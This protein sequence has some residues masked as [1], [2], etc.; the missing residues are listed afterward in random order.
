MK[1]R[2]LG[3][4]EVVHGGRPLSIR[5]ARQRAVL[6]ALLVD[7]NRVVPL[8]VLVARVWD[9][10]PPSRTALHNLVMRLRHALGPDVIETRA[11]GYL[12]E[13]SDEDL[14]V[15][16]FDDLVRRA[17]TADPRQAS[18]LLTE[19]L[20]LWRGEPLADVP[21]EVLHREVVPGLVERRLAAVELRIEAD[22][23]LGGHSDLVPELREL[24]D[25]H[26]LREHFWH[27]RMRALHL[28]GRQAEALDCFRQVREVLR[29]ELGVDPGPELRALHQRILV[30]EHRRPT[31]TPVPRQ[32]PTR[33]P[34]FVGRA[35]ELRHLG[36]LLDVAA[37]TVVISAVNGSAGIGKTTLAV[38]WAHQ[39]AD[40][41][42]DGQLYVDLRGFDADNAPTPPS[43]AV[44]GFLTALDVPSER[45]PATLD[46]QTALYRSLLAD[47]RVLVLLDNARDADQVRPLL[48]ASPTCLVLITSRNQLTGLVA[49][50]GARPIPLD[51][52][53]EADALA[54]L[55]GHLGARRVDADPEAAAELVEHCA[56]VPLAVALMAARAAVNARLSLRDLA[57]DLR[58][59]HTRL[60]T[61]DD[62]DP[63]NGVRAVFSYSYRQVSP[64]AARLFRLLGSHPGPDVSVAAAASL[65]GVPITEANGLVDE[66]AAAHLLHAPTPGRFA[67]HDLL[68][69]YAVEQPDD[70][71]RDAVRRLL[72]HYRYAAAEANRLVHVARSPVDLDAP[73]PDVH[74]ESFAGIEAAA[75]WWDAEH[76][77]LV[78]AV[79]LAAKQGFDRHAWQIAWAIAVDLD[80][81]G[82]WV[83]W[84]DTQ[85][86]ALAAAE[87]LGD[88]R[89]QERAH[90]ALG[91]AHGRLR[92]L[93]SAR[94][95]FTH[96]LALGE[97]LGDPR[98]QAGAHNNLGWMAEQDGRFDVALDHA[99]RS[100]AL[101]EEVGDRSAQGR[102]HGAAGW[103]YARLGELD[104][105]LVHAEAARE[106]FR[107]LE[108]PRYL[109][110]A[111]DTIGF[112][113]LGAGRYDLAVEHLREAAALAVGDRLHESTILTHL[114]DALAASGDPS[115]ARDVWRK[116]LGHLEELGI[117][118]EAEDLRAKLRGS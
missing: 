29:D 91:H 4:L 63:A 73:G 111:L 118:D 53:D 12:V 110:A 9:D 106:V 7:A 30:G 114:G 49:R 72:D 25:R 97:S 2:L 11:E 26:P 107:D 66:L 87:R 79:S 54:L 96:A 20:A 8:E 60:D 47:R 15:R 48:P 43:H 100:L 94:K 45:V 56:G 46:S 116:A 16:L 98:T 108:E 64:G 42:P 41:F 104:L 102:A 92:D 36:R 37:E 70:G 80:R 50:E 69:A 78:A 101:Y 32:L 13:A 82:H 34:H 62:D 85:S 76:R 89:P 77:V 33:T 31:T 103:D 112:A 58:D 55:R 95:H 88:L 84:I 1:F 40:R 99:L 21:S 109:A 93:E 18:A 105:A 74:R 3:P 19:A 28:A 57:D 51:L 14:D 5:A 38:H 71:R 86:T 68:R 75:R 27:Q 117:T 24:T 6:A 17:R 65:A 22:L 81:G 90:A 61:L 67:L 115:A 23:A 44:R 10:D 52:L 35:T 113:H 83:E 59:E 39:A